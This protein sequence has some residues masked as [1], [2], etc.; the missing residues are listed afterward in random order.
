MLIIHRF[1]LTSGDSRPGGRAECDEGASRSASE[2]FFRDEDLAKTEARMVVARRFWL[3]Q[4]LVGLAQA[5]LTP[6]LSERVDSR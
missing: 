1:L 3:R 6:K 5:W 2:P 4:V